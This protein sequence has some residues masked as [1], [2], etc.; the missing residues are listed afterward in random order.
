[1]LKGLHISDIGVQFKNII[2]NIFTFALTLNYAVTPLRIGIMLGTQRFLNTHGI[3][4][5]CK[6]VT[7]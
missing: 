3:T 1:M 4:G 6:F 7:S 2:F 5:I